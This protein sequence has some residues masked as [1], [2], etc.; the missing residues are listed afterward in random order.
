MPSE[1]R[2]PLETLIRPGDVSP[3]A[4]QRF[5][6]LLRQYSRVL[7]RLEYEPLLARVL[8]LTVFLT[9]AILVTARD[10]VGMCAFDAASALLAMYWWTIVSWLKRQQEVLESLLF[11]GG[12][13]VRMLAVEFHHSDWKQSRARAIIKFE[14]VLWVGLTILFGFIR[15]LASFVAKQ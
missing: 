8:L 14:P 12:G 9:L 7:A 5:E 10:L 11:R 3:E 6:I 15:Y 1:E 4:D 2:D 13:R